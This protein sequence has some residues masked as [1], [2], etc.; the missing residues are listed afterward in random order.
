[1]YLSLSSLP[2]NRESPAWVAPHAYDRDGDGDGDGDGDCGSGDDGD[3]GLTASP[4][5]SPNAL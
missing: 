2:H 3:D 5:F 4:H 1:M